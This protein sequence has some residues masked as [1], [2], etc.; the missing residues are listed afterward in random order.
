MDT[1][2]AVVPD[3]ESEIARDLARRT[4]FVAPIVLIVAGLWQGWEGVVGAALGLVVV[5]ANFLVLAKLMATGAKAGAQAVAFAAML[6]YAVLLIVVTLLAVILRGISQVDL[7][8]FVVTIA[9]VHLALL[10]LELPKLGLTPGAPGLKP[11]PLAHS[12][13]RSEVR[14]PRVRT[15][16]VG[17]KESR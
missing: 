15:P 14:T 17:T 8:S 2:P 12:D 16:R 3:H 1:T 9:I 6:S 5:A 7:A 10:F 11:R 13:G 4:L